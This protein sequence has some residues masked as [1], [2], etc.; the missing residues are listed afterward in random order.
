MVLWSIHHVLDRKVVCSN[1]V[2]PKSFSIQI[3]KNISSRKSEQKKKGTLSLNAS[4]RAVAVEE[5]E[6]TRRE[7]EEA[8]ASFEALIL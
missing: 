2:S 1:L 7:R 3:E 5:E 6:E 8:E 4:V